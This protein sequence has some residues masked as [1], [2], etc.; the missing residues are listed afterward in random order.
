M[1]LDARTQFTEAPWELWFP[2]AAIA[3]LI[4]CFN[5][6]S[7]GLRRVLRNEE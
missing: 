6:M 4:I 2:V 5:L 1:V 3:A 7:D